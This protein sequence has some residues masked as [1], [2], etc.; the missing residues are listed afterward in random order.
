ME[1]YHIHVITSLSEIDTLYPFWEKN[2]QHPLA[3]FDL[4][5]FVVQTRNNVISPCI[6]VIS[7][8]QLPIA[9]LVGRIETEKFPIR[10]GYA[11][12]GHA[13]VRQLVVVS[14]GFLGNESDKAW[15]RMLA[16]V[17][18]LMPELRIDFTV[19]E[20]LRFG[21]P[22]YLFVKEAFSPFQV[23]WGQKSSKHWLLR[24]PTNW[25]D[26]MKSRSSKHRYWIKRLI[27]VLDREFEGEWRMQSYSSPNE[28][29]EFVLASEVIAKT[30]YQRRLKAG[31]FGNKESLGRVELDARKGR[32]RGYVLFIKNEPKAFWYCHSYNRTLYLSAT[33]YDP[34]YRKYELGTV[35]L[36]KVFQDHCGTEIK[37]VDFGLG[38]AGYKQRFGSDYFTETTPLLFSRSARG[39][40]LNSLSRIIGGS[41]RLAQIISD[42]L[43]TTMRLKT[44]WRRRLEVGQPDTSL[45]EE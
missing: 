44:L 13:R 16:S 6:F 11:T 32:L 8:D 30:T 21:S 23:Y 31:F 33:G 28:V 40:Y 18:A 34:S 17:S 1:D 39:L 38:D 36:M 19:F 25:D 26:F 42:K 5:S 41:N 10:F 7:N 12:L 15:P 35:L 24:L 45:S 37:V 4:F 27:R 29:K 20:Q 3:D 9:L 14:G 22:E 43:G 2:Q